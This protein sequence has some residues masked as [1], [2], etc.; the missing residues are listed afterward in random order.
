MHPSIIEEYVAGRL[1]PRAAAPARPR[2]LNADERR[3]LAF[4]RDA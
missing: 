2:G 4:L 1:P 3:L